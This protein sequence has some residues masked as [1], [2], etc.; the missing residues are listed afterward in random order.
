M[1]SK[2]CPINKLWYGGKGFVKNNETPISSSEVFSLIEDKRPI[3]FF[4]TKNA[5]IALITQ[6]ISR[7]WG[8]VGQEP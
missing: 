2:S 7:V 5:H 3:F 1:L 8:A 6:E 4:L